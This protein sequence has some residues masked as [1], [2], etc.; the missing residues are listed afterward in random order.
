MTAFTDEDLLDFSR[1]RFAHWDEGALER[2]LS[3]QPDLFRDHLAI[4]KWIDH[5]SDRIENDP[6]LSDD[7]H[8]GFAVGMREVAKH[9]RLG[10]LV[11]GGSLMRHLEG[12]GPAGSERGGA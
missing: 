4:A 11:P 3:E 1:A 10:D 8:R 5:W 9:L 6:S 2:L 7:Y 12:R